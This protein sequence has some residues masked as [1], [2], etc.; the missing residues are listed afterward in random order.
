LTGGLGDD[1]YVIDNL[2]DVIH[3][4]SGEGN[5]TVE[6]SIDYTLAEQLENLTLVGTATTAIGNEVDNILSGNS[7]DNRLEGL[8]GNDTFI[9]SAG[10]DE[11]LGGGGDDIYTLNQ[12][13]GVDNISDTQGLNV[14]ELD[15][16]LSDHHLKVYQ[17][18]IEGADYY[19]LSVADE[20]GS[21]LS[22]SGALLA[23][24]E[25]DTFSVRQASGA[26]VSLSSLVVTESHQGSDDNDVIDT[27]VNSD[28]IIAGAGHDV[29][30]SR[31]GFDVIDAGAGND[32][33][34]AGSGDDVIR[35]GEGD[36]RLF[37][38]TGN[39]TYLFNS[40]DGDDVIS[41]TLDEQGGSDSIEFGEGITTDQ[42]LFSMMNDDLL[43]TNLESSDSIVVEGWSQG[44]T[45]ES[46]TLADGQSID[47]SSVDL[48][49]QAMASF[50]VEG[51]DGEVTLS[52]G[53]E[54]Q[55]HQLA[56]STWQ[57]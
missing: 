9:Q 6:S 39:D 30:V 5:D 51:G 8:L 17:V 56:D 44:H 18:T 15:S 50:V 11:L 35:G 19:R 28:I 57:G 32:Q 47:S 23:V 40:G 52:A 37:G 42:L 55:H 29:I 25:S 20:N 24:T 10:N 4:L 7:A 27:G 43:V 41:E 3:E 2:G 45:I 22:A 38:G 46:F 12:S 49:V 33:V 31:G 54:E 36:D 26:L 21:D 48:L 1:T 14:I 34:Y 53:S 16:T 13:I